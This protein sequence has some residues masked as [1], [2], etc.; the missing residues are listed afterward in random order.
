MPVSHP[1]PAKTAARFSRWKFSR[2]FSS[3]RFFLVSSTSPSPPCPARRGSRRM[4]WEHARAT[5]RPRY[6]PAVDTPLITA[7]FARA[8]G[9]TAVI[10]HYRYYRQH[11]H[12]HPLLFTRYYRHHRPIRRG[13][14]TDSRCRDAGNDGTRLVRDRTWLHYRSV[15]ITTVA[16]VGAAIRRDG[17]NDRGVGALG[18]RRHAAAVPIIVCKHERRG[19]VV[20]GDGRK[21]QKPTRTPTGTRR[22]GRPRSRCRHGRGMNVVFLFCRYVRRSR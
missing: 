22:F 6:Q 8:R 2:R 4:A 3:L 14:G 11:R 7:D 19:E 10:N 12:R 13:I 18:R 17:D 20:D 9:H 21:K 5:S 16:T 1:I 15:S